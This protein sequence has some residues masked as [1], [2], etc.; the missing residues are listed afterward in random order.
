[1]TFELN[2]RAGSTRLQ[3]WLVDAAGEVR[4]AYFVEVEHVGL[5]AAG[6]PGR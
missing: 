1:V 5:W 4:G 6:G 2:L 3:T